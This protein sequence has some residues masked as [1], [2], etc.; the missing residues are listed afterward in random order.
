[1][2]PDD[3][4]KGAKN[5]S[6]L[7]PPQKTEAKRKPVKPKV[8]PPK[9]SHSAGKKKSRRPQTDK[10]Q[11]KAPKTTILTKTML[12]R[13]KP[14]KTYHSSNNLEIHSSSGD[15]SNQSDISI[16]DSEPDYMQ[17]NGTKRY[18]KLKQTIK[19]KQ[20]KY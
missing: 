8:A 16:K 18:L 1:M 12:T 4:L 10:K 7:K 9:K 2:L 11:P 20:F 13:K 6:K 14:L 5:K 3:L 15:S 19:G 17:I